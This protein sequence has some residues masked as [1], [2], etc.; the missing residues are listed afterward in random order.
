MADDT[1]STPQDSQINASGTDNMPGPLAQAVDAANNNVVTQN[2][3]ESVPNDKGPITG[4]TPESNAAQHPFPGDQTQQQSNQQ[5]A[6]NAA[7]LSKAATNIPNTPDAPSVD[8]AVAKAGKVH[9]ILQALSGGQQYATTINPNTGQV[10]RKPVPM[11]NAQYAR[12]LA[13]AILTGAFRGLEEKG[14]G[15]EGRAAAGGFNAVL[16]QKQKQ[17]QQQELEASQTYA[18]QAAI[19]Q[20]NFQTRENALRLSNMDYDFQ[21]KIAAGNQDT[22]QYARDQGHVL[23]EDVAPEDLF[24]KYNVTKDQAIPS[25]VIRVDNPDG[26]TSIKTLYTV[27]DP[28]GSIQIPQNVAAEAAAHHV[29]GTFK[30]DENGKTAPIDFS[31][32]AAAKLRF[33]NNL[34]QTSAS[35]NITEK[36]LDD[37]LQELGQATNQ[38]FAPID[39]K[40]A[41]DT[42]AL[43][44]KA[45]KAFTPFAG[46]SNIDEAIDAFAKSKAN[47]DSGGVLAS[48][49]R[50]LLPEGA[51]DAAKKQTEDKAAKI[52]S[53]EANAAAVSKQK[54]ELPGIVAE[55][56]A[57]AKV[58][59]AAAYGRSYSSE[60]GRIAAKNKYDASSGA[61]KD[62]VKNPK[63]NAIAETNETPVNGVNQQYFKSLQDADPNMAAVVKAIGEGRQLQ[64]KYGL[65]KED[66]QRLAAIVNRA[67]PE[68]SQPK[69]EAYEKLLNSFTSGDD[70]K[71]IESGNTT[72]RHIQDYV[73]NANK[74]G[75]SVPGAPTRVGLEKDASQLVEEVNSAYTKGVLHE[76]QR[77]NLIKGLSSVIPEY[78]TTAARELTKLLSAKTSEKLGTFRRGAVTSAT[79]D[80]EV[81]SPEA[82]DA[83]NFVMG[84]QADPNFATSRTKAG[85][86][87]NTSQAATQPYTPPA[88][89]YRKLVN[90]AYQYK[91]P[92]NSIVDANGKP[93]TQ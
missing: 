49:I 45:V 72:Y 82:R 10:D 78:R 69:A 32:G 20:T 60:E 11:S 79:P 62:M 93:V 90:G 37:K 43:S 24:P 23:G 28:E 2:S 26:S 81:V 19:A 21:S 75:S 88:G 40:K 3:Q 71:Q 64:S 18:R 65:A 33:V 30:I 1:Q 92:D 55:A 84:N 51:Y 52:K 48:Q 44:T 25:R 46:Y 74:L 35:T 91:L 50:S 87:Q 57:K 31:G 4:G 27:I 58:E 13:A 73:E 6:L 22:I 34:L 8:P 76:D 29:P 14:P 83:Y 54:A 53:D 70:K 7:D 47:T 41:Y 12:G 36:S 39:I 42:G 67:Y 63:I 86:N 17:Q 85:V 66:G 56:A 16:E 15:A 9:T 38:K 59:N 80:F 68:Y 61:I 5:G 77:A 89:S